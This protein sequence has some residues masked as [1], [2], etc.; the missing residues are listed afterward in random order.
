MTLGAGAGRSRGQGEDGP[1]TPTSP[2]AHP[3]SLSDTV[4]RVRGLPEPWHI[5]IRPVST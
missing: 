4:Y 5:S 1:R 3:L 2:P